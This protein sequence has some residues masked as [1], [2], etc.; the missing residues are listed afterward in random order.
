MT[1]PSDAGLN[2]GVKKIIQLIV[3]LSFGALLLW[4]SFRQVELGQAWS[5]ITA[6]PWWQYLLYLSLLMITHGLRSERFRLQL[7]RMTG[8]PVPVSEGLAQFSVGV[9]ATFLIPFR[10]G[11]FVRPYLGKVRGYLSMS[12]GMSTVAAE[13]VIDGLTTTALLGFVLLLLD[14][15]RVPQVVYYGGYAALAVF[16][17]AF[18]VFVVGYLQRERTVALLRTM[19]G[20]LSTKLGNKIADVADGFL[21][22]LNTLPSW[23]DL[24][25]Y[26]AFTVGY[27]GLNGVSM[28]LLMRGM[29]IDVDWL[30]GFFVLSCLVIGVMIPAPPGNVGN[31]EY[32]I[33]LP[34]TALGVDPALA[35]A[36]AVVLHFMQA[37]Q[38]TA[39]AMAFIGSGKVSLQRVVEATQQ[40]DGD[41][42]PS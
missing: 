37:G 2:R 25:L 8:Q 10:L 23:K 29:G 19:I 38:M 22:G 24:L 26:Q 13:R 12:Q 31:F 3:S 27:W 36:Y 15:G 34:L 30:G 28:I 6:T 41:P 20:W 14:P 16:G 18:V 33:V 40:G 11:E 1:G 17:G 42:S 9:A 32:A 21:S 35:A 4:L 5:Y 7:K 39:V